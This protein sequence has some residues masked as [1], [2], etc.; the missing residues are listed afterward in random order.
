[1]GHI[2]VIF[3]KQWSSVYWVDAWKMKSVSV[4]RRKQRVF[5]AVKKHYY[6]VHSYKGKQLIGNGLQFK[7]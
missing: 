3:Q 1:M 6:Q 5:I 4:I 7:G 2:A